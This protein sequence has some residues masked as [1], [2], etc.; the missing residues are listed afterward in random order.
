MLDELNND[1][2]IR[3]I[4]IA[5]VEIKK[6][7]LIKNL[8]DKNDRGIYIKTTANLSRYSKILNDRKMYLL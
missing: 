7:R 2:N 1:K 5:C 4:K 3:I 8:D 6:F